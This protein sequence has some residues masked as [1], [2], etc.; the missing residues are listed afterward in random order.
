[1]EHDV[2]GDQ[3]AE[4][5]EDTEV[6]PVAARDDLPCRHRGK[7]RQE[8]DVNQCGQCDSGLNRQ[9]HDKAARQPKGGECGQRTSADRQAPGPVRDR[10]QQKA[11]RDGG[12]VAV[13]HF[14]DVPIERRI[15]RTK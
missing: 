11:R 10:G 6:S 7:G 12:D 9:Q 13:Q 8:G 4:D 5:S 15:G 14:V 1:M 3:Q 2:A